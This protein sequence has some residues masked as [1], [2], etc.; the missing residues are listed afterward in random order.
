M[1]EQGNARMVDTG[2]KAATGRRAVA[3]A[4]VRMKAETAA[5][6]Q[7]GALGKGDALAVARI[8]GIMAAK[9]TPRL[10]PLCHNVN[11]TSVQVNFFWAEKTAAAAIL[12]I[13]ATAKAL[14]RTGVEM[15]AL[16]AASVAALTVYD[17]CKGVDD[18]LAVESVEL[19]EKT[20]GKKPFRRERRALERAGAVARGR[21]GPGAAGAEATSGPG[22]AG[23]GATSGP[24]AVGAKATSGPGVSGVEGTSGS[25]GGA[26]EGG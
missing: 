1:D 4:A 21:S 9:D 6:L 13:E 5:L 7:Q 8:A 22:V 16:V 19:L 14:D 17:M 2:H 12:D 24:G 15:E 25:G 18:T 11:L 26:A 23:A 10:I 20:G 3:A